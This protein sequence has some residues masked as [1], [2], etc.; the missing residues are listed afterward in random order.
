MKNWLYLFAGLAIGGAAGY[1][2]AHHM[3][4]QKMVA[5]IE[6]IRESYRK[7]LDGIL[8]E[9]KKVL[10][11]DKKRY[12][13]LVNAHNYASKAEEPNDVV[14]MEEGEV[15]DK[16]A[17][18]PIT[19]DVF[20]GMEPDDDE[21]EVDYTYDKVSWTYYA[22]GILADENNDVVGPEDIKEDVGANFF[23]AFKDAENYTIYVRNPRFR[24]D[25]EIV[26]SD[27]N[28]ADL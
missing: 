20:N 5:E 1:S 9:K 25:Y 19:A 24:I 27:M 21:E 3:Y 23:K 14:E 28:Y 2:V 7:S 18:H 15:K 8:E 16:N 6:S 17:P 10:E 13:S 4:S 22:D 12:D 26:E 11:E